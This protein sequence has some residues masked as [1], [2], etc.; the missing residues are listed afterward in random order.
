MPILNPNATLIFVRNRLRAGLVDPARY[1]DSDLLNLVNEAYLDACEQTL[2]LQS[3]HTI[4]TVAEQAEY[5]LPADFS[6]L[7][8]VVSAGQELSLLPLQDSLQGLT[9]LQPSYYLYGSKIGLVPT[10]TVNSSGEAL[11]LYAAAPPLLTS[12][13]DDLDGRFPSEFSD[14]L[15]HYVRWRTQL[16]SGG[17]ERLASASADR[18]TYDLR[19]KQ[20]RRR[21]ES[22]VQTGAPYVRHISDRRQVLS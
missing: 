22:V 11:L 6:A 2:C 4:T 10:P 5:A 9:N 20:L 18:G 7:I 19:I 14:V 3:L 15:V 21:Y 13:E 8:R 1:T 12:F 17:A 16:L